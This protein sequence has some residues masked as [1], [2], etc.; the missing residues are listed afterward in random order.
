MHFVSAIDNSISFCYIRINTFLANYRTTNLHIQ[1]S[2]S[3]STPQEEKV[4]NS[5]SDVMKSR[6]ESFINHGEKDAELAD[7]YLDKRKEIKQLRS[8][9]K[10]SI[11]M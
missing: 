10:H 9:P 6:I 3:S 8:V 7:Q 4:V 1:P 5:A 11:G 2:N